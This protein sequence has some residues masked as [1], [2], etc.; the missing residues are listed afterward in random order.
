M[1]AWLLVTYQGREDDFEL[2]Q[3][4]EL[5]LARA[6]NLA[7]LHYDYEVL[8]D[9]QAD[10]WWIEIPGEDASFRILKLDVQHK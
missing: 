5:A 10:A 7:K 8:S 2:F 6:K 1:S 3:T 9:E 4:K